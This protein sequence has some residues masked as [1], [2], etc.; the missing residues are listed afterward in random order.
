MVL[1]GQRSDCARVLL[2]YFH[3]RRLLL[4]PDREPS[5]D[6]QPKRL[7]RRRPNFGGRLSTCAGTPVPRR[8][9]R[10]DDRKPRRHGLVAERIARWRRQRRRRP[11]TCAAANPARC[12]RSRSRLRCWLVSPWTDLALLGATLATKDAIDPLIHRGYLAELAAA[13]ASLRWTESPGSALYANPVMSPS[14][15]WTGQRP[16]RRWLDGDSRQARPGPPMSLG[17]SK[18]GRT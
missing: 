8:A 13:S 18:F 10:R 4:R 12:G 6:G 16:R 11:D 14:P 7:R 15:R 2:P 5:P 1:R 3:G 17:R 9:G